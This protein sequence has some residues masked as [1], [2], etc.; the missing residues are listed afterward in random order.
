MVDF[1]NETTIGT[2]AVDVQRIS[3]LQRRYDLFE[4][5]ENYQKR[6][7]D[8]VKMSSAVVKARLMTLFLE[9]Q[10]LIKRK[11]KEKEYQGMRSICLGENKDITFEQVLKVIFQLNELLDEIRLT[12]V[13]NKQSYNPMDIEKENQM[14][15][16]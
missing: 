15:G 7:F 16:F 9:I 12:R 6:S 4:A 14:K 13:D 5:I 3:I 8:N 10:P 11:Y 2:P 1:N